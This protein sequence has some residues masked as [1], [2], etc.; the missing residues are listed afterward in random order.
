MLADRIAL[1]LA[2]RIQQDGLPQDFYERPAS[3]TVARFFGTQNFVPGVVTGRTFASPL[4]MLALAHDH[5]AGDGFLVIR[6][7]AIELGDGENSFEATIDRA[8]YLGTHVRVWARAA[9]IVLQF[10][11]APGVPYEAGAAVRLRLPSRQTW[12]VPAKDTIL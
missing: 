7:E 9:G 5:P 12:V 4:G 8:M 11:D 2:G 6:Q 3:Q 1:L 10:T